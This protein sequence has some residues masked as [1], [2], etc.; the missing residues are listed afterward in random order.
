MRILN[1]VNKIL[2]LKANNR[3][4]RTR[5]KICSTLIIK[6]TELSPDLH[7]VA[8]FANVRGCKKFLRKLLEKG[9]KNIVST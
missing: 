8:S 4:T 3:N 5:C 7:D 9:K 2:S 1:V 6:T